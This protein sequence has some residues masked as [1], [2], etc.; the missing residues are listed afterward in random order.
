M[1]DEDMASVVVFLR[2]LPAVRHEL[3]KTEII[4]PVKYLIRGVPEPLTSPV[5]EDDTS[6]AIKHGSHLVNLAGC[7]DCH[8]QRARGNNLPGLAFAGWAMLSG[9]WGNVADANLAPDA[10]GMTYYT[11]ALLPQAIHR[12]PFG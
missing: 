8:T 7:S 11:Q 1:S 4:F 5:G 10:T 6:D 3:P 9:P 2:S 12:G